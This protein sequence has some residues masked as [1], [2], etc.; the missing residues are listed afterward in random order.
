MQIASTSRVI[1]LIDQSQDHTNHRNAGKLQT[2]FMNTSTTRLD[3]DIA[4]HPF[5][6]GMSEHHLTKRD[7]PNSQFVARDF[8]KEEASPFRSPACRLRNARV[9]NASSLHKSRS[10]AP[11]LP[12]L[13]NHVGKDLREIQK[14][15]HKNIRTTVR[16]THVGNKQTRQR[17]EAPGQALK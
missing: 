16:Y 2:N 12:I 3:A 6:C 4:A 13:L 15:L 14:L 10:L 5:V 1:D 7:A 17:A 8:R 11:V 9:S